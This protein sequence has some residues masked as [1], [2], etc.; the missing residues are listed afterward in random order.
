MH[1]VSIRPATLA[2]A[3]A[4]LAV[5]RQLPQWFNEGGFEQ[6]SR[7]LSVH[8]GAVA[9][10]DGQIVGFVTWSPSPELTD[11][12]DISWLGVAPHLRGGGI[13]RRLVAAME[14]SVRTGGIHT[15][16]VSTLAE[17]CDYPPYEETRQFYFRLGFR[18]ERIDKGHYSPEEDR[19]LLI[20]SI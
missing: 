9:V 18:T 13:G 3:P 17:T 15:V 10:Q 8:H 5:A 7:D 1:E 16:T 6:M 20:K 19:L 2:D 4:M 11:A 12:M 14:E